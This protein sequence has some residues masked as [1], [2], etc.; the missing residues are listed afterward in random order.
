MTQVLSS[1]T[2]SSAA[3]E[4]FQ[5]VDEVVISICAMFGCDYECA[6]GLNL[7]L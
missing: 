4:D 5:T 2:T 6:C 3:P 1:S 7:C